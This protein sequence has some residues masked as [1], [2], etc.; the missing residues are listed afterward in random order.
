MSNSALKI[1][2]VNKNKPASG[3]DILRV[4][5]LL[6][7]ELDH[8]VDEP[9]II[10][11]YA[12]L[13]IT[14]GEGKHTIDFVE[15]P[16]EEGTILTIRKGQV[17]QFER[18]A[19]VQGYL[20]LLTDDFLVS[21]FNEGQVF[22]S[23]QL[24]NNMLESP[25]IQLQDQKHDNIKVLIDQIWYEYFTT[26]DESSESITRSLLQVILLRLHRIRM[27][28]QMD[29]DAGKKYNSDFLKLQQLIEENCFETR[30][31]LD[32]AQWMHCT[33]KTLNNITR[34][35]I[36]KSA[37]SLIDDIAILKIKRLLMAENDTV[38]EIAYATG[39]DDASNFHKYFKK[40]T[41]VSPETYRNQ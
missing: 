11:F 40:H 25:S 17:H 7:K 39:F 31:V 41:G 33:S 34:A 8:N 3:F 37:K 1:S 4:E 18:N 28:N 16:F 38:A 23:L 30:K 5:E 35:I 27:S 32:Y 13:V 10:Q 20:I 9:H 6:A 14:K 26:N 21:Y 29:T 19:D 36:S 2:F 12:V 24:F 22:K 15:Y